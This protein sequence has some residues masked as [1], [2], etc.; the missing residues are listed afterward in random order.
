MPT[1]FQGVFK[2][3]YD[4]AFNLLV[5]R[6]RKYGPENIRSQGI[7]G[8]LTRLSDDKIARVKQSL[9]GTVV[10]GKIELEPILDAEATDTFED[11]LLDIANYALIALSLH[12]GVWG[13]PLDEDLDEDEEEGIDI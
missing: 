7:Y 4:E 6:Q 9:Q 11:A 8:V 5:E 2:E 1:S 13:F 12:R 3:I 10:N